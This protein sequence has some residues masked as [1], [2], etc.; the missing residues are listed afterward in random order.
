MARRR[1]GDLGSHLPA[2]LTMYGVSGM[3]HAACRNG[4]D[5]RSQMNTA[6]T[7]TPTSPVDRS[8]FVDAMSCLYSGVSVVTTD[9]PGGRRALTVTAM[10]SVSADPPTILVCVR[11]LSPI[12]AIIR[13]NN[14][15]CVNILADNQQHI[16][17]TFAGRVRTGDPY[18]FGIAEWSTRTTG[19]PVL[20]GAVA[21]FDCTLNTALEVGS[22]TIFLGE[23]RCICNREG[24]P[25]IY[26]RRAYARAEEAR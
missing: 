12:S 18:D 5:S 15:F 10:S 21:A 20:S 8:S 6:D 3:L 24:Q 4:R 7:I 22:H 9:G 14:A 26:G 2:A 23:V 19:S 13:A 16:S 25:L 17:E 11:S 1:D